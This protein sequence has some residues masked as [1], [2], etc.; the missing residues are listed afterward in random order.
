M[1]LPGSEFY[2]HS[3]LGVLERWYCRLF[4]IPIIGLRIRVR[5]LSDLLPVQASRILDAGCGRGV[6]S[7][8]LARR[9]RDASVDAVDENATAQEVNRTLSDAMLL[10]N[11]HFIT[12]DLLNLS[13]KNYYDLI[14]SVDN[15]EHVQDD[16]TLLKVFYNAM[17]P[18]GL[19]VLHVPHYYRRWP[20]FTW[21]KNFD[22]PGHVRPG[23]HLPEINERVL[24]AGFSIVR[25][26][27]SYNF[28]ENLINNISYAITGAQEK[29]KVIYAVLFP[30][31]NFIAWAGHRKMPR[32]GAGVWVIARKHVES[33]HVPRD[34]VQENED[35]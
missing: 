30:L 28:L 13:N 32:K 24:R 14:V 21:R 17:L 10:K 3:S 26:G 31:L 33:A 4:G 23:Y 35:E 34:D 5:I 9:Y 18:A 1:P 7:R 19:L 20:V 2:R 11:C 6:I 27:F 29:N 12:D 16:A 8:I 22:V 15:L 25:T